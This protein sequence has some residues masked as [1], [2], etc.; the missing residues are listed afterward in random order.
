MAS[1]DVCFNGKGR[2]HFIPEKAKV[3]VKLCWYFATETGST[4][5]SSAASWLHFPT[6]WH[7]CIHC[8]CG[9]RLDCH[10]LQRIHRQGRVATQPSGPES[11]EWL[12]LRDNARL[13]PY[14]TFQPKS[15]SIDELIERCPAVN[16]T[17]DNDNEVHFTLATS[18]SR[19][20]KYRTVVQ[21]TY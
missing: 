19:I 6:G 1:S 21:K 20:D 17:I 18:N 2:L 4:L 16:L 3:N 11:T 7:T 8:T 9:T 5:Q 10:Q 13:L 12:R 14:H 15:K